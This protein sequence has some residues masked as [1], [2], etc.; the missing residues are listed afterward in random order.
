MSMLK[1]WYTLEEAA[2]KFGVEERQISGWVEKGVVRTEE[3]K[4]EA[5]RV[6]GDDL[7]LLVQELTGL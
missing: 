6:N 5:L 1:T 3:I 2:A 7:E 4:G